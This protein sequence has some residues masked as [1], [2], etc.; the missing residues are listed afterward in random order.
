MYLALFLLIISALVSAPVN[1]AP[2][3]KGR[4]E[5]GD[6]F[7]KLARPTAKAVPQEATPDKSGATKPVIDVSDFMF[8]NAEEFA[9]KTVDAEK[10]SEKDESELVI[11]WENWHRR[12]SAIIYRRWKVYGS[13]SGE[14]KVRLTVSREGVIN[15]KFLSFLEQAEDEYEETVGEQAAFE[16]KVLAALASL[17]HNPALEFPAQSKRQEVVL[18]TRFTSHSGVGPSGYSWKRGDYERVRP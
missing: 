12:V 17:N 5:T 2:A 13:V 6:V 7:V 10:K 1:C 4:V 18:N 14:A 3:I 16:S 11:A 9:Q 15:V 8:G